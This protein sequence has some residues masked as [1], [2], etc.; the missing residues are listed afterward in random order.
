MQNN[1]ELTPNVDAQYRT[2]MVLW[3]AML[4]FDCH[5]FRAR[6]RCAD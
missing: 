3:F 2:M 6:Y 1:Q 4:V 5:V